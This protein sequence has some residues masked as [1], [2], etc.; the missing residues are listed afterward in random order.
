MLILVVAIALRGGQGRQE[1]WA[2]TND[3]YWEGFERSYMAF[4]QGASDPSVRLDHNPTQSKV[5]RACRYVADGFWVYDEIRPAW[6]R[7]CIDGTNE[8]LRTG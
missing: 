1:P 3:P 6:L 8:W 2:L 4:D 5:A 7:G